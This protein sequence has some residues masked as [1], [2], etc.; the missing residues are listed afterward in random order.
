MTRTIKSIVIF[1]LFTFGLTAVALAQIPNPQ[2]P[3]QMPNVEVSDEEMKSFVEITM[4]AQQIQMEAQTEMI[5]MVEEAGITVERFNEI[6]TGMQNGQS[7]ADMGMDDEEMKRFDDV[8]D[9]LESVQ[10]KVEGQIVEVIES[11]GM[12]LDRFQ[13]INFA[14]QMDPEL[15]E[16]FRQYAMEMS[17]GM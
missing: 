6:L 7:Q 5:E 4:D 10:E 1:S 8:L 11:K 16:K 3:A 15:Q 13:E 12:E 14:I 9:E 17:N 2:M